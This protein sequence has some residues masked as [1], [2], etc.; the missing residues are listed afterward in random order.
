MNMTTHVAKICRS[1]TTCM[2]F[3]KSADCV[4]SRTHQTFL[5]TCARSTHSPSL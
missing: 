1:H 3:D 5:Y 4:G 2:W